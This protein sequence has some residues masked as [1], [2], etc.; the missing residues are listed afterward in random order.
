MRE[1]FKRV[2][3][4][5]PVP[6]TKSKKSNFSSKFLKYL[7]ITSIISSLSHLGSKVCLLVLNSK[8]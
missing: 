4:R 3:I 8:L 5:L 6:T 7:K 1:Y 2:I